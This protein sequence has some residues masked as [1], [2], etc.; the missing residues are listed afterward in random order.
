MSVP[1]AATPT[2]PVSI[3][4][5]KIRTE[6]T[7]L[8]AESVLVRLAPSHAS[9]EMI[10]VSTPPQDEAAEAGVGTPITPEAS[11]TTAHSDVIPIP[12]RWATLLW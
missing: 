12:M 5:T 2:A 7:G 8:S 9:P 1:T 11:S 4:I 10:E 3:F 6:T